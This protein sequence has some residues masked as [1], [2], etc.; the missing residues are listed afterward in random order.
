MILINFCQENHACSILKED[1]DKVISVMMPCTIFVYQ[2]SYGHAYVGIMNAGL[3][4][5]VFGGTVAEVMD[6]TVPLSSKNY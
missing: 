1:P 4:G 5:T 3:L 2:K 6:G